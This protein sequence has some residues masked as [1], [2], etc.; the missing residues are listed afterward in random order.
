MEKIDLSKNVGTKIVM[1]IIRTG[2]VLNR[3]LE[4]ELA[5]HG[6][7]PIRFGVMNALIVH[8]GKMTPTAISK[9]TF[10]A[11]HTI[12]S[13]LRVLEGIGFIKREPSEE[14]QRSVDIVIT[15]KG[16]IATKKM[17]PLAEQMSK[18]ALSCF[19]DEQLEILM[20]LLKDF[21]KHLLQQI[22][23]TRGSMF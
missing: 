20:P 5:K 12:T 11:K 4:I 8:N 23:N 10:R 6:S 2:D 17:I 14:D 22:E 21:R 1:S 15:K 7:S 13:M 9:W 19:D 3:Y 18:G 16:W